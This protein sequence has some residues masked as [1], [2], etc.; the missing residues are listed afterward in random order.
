MSIREKEG[1]VRREVGR[2]IWNKEEQVMQRER[3]RCNDH[4]YIL[5]QVLQVV[6]C[7]WICMYVLYT[8]TLS[9]TW[10]LQLWTSRRHYSTT[11]LFGTSKGLFCF[12]YVRFVNSC[13]KKIDAHTSV[14]PQH[15]FAKQTN[16]NFMMC[17]WSL[18]CL[19]IDMLSVYACGHIHQQERPYACP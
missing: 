10:H 3:S 17:T 12:A 6:L 7:V 8:Y 1:D 2:G 5:D 14:Y 11:L 9:L 15:A 19:C 13:R 4:D 16:L 18:I